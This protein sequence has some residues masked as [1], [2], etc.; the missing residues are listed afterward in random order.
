MV[1]RLAL[2]Q[3]RAASYEIRRTIVVHSRKDLFCLSA[4]T[5]TRVISCM[6]KFIIIQKGA[7]ARSASRSL[8]EK[9]SILQVENYLSTHRT[10]RQTFSNIVLIENGHELILG[11]IPGTASR[12]ASP[13]Q[14]DTNE[15]VA[16]SHGCLRS[17]QLVGFKKC[18]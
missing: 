6:A 4:P 8:F 18:T 9:R 2:T 14:L 11:R 12:S 15:Q 1:S 10:Q 3:T 17:A 16:C 5:K 7:C 13:G